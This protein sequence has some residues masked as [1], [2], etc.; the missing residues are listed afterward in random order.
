[1]K[2]D[3]V[4]FL[5]RD[6]FNSDEAAQAAFNN[7]IDSHYHNFFSKGINELSIKC[8]NCIVNKSN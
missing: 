6:K 7:F 5:A 4:I 1:M 2:F 8:R 3:K